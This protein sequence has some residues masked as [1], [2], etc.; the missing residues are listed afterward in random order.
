[1]K[2]KVIIAVI[3]TIALLVSSALIYVNNVFLPVKIKARLTQELENNL[4]KNVRIE[5]LRYS[6]IKGLAIQNLVIYDKSEDQTYLSAEEIS[7]NLLILPLFKK[8]IIIPFL[9]IDSPK[10]Y[11]KVKPDN[12]LNLMELFKTQTTQE[13][14]RFSFIISK[15]DLT[16]GTLQFSDERL[17]F[18]RKVTDLKI[19]A[20]LNLP[21]AI[22][23]ILQAKIQNFSASP[24]FI[25]AT[26]EYN[27]FK[28]DLAAKVKLANLAINDY[29]LY[30]NK[31]PLAL[32]DGVVNAD[33]EIGLKDRQLQVKGIT[34]ARGVKT[35][36]LD[37][38]LDI[39]GNINLSEN[40]LNW[41]NFVITYKQAKFNSSGNIID[42][43]QPKID[44]NVGAKDFT[45][46]TSLAIQDKIIK[47]NSCAG[48]YLNSEFSIN[49]N[50]DMRDNANPLINL[51]LELGLSLKDISAK[52]DGKCKIK[53][54][55]SG[56]IIKDTR[57][58]NAAL[59]FSAP[60]LSISD[61]KL[62]NLYFTLL[63]KN[64][65]ISINDLTAKLYSG[66]LNLQLAADIGK[67]LPTYTAKINLLN[68]DLAKLKMDTKFKDKDISGLLN[69]KSDI[70]QDLKD[71]NTLQGEGFI[72]IKDGKLWEWDLLKGV[73][74]LLFMPIY[75]KIIFRDARV[76]FNI[77]NKT[78]SIVDSSLES[79][80]LDLSAEGKIGF[81]G[82]LDL[83]LH[84]ELNEDLIK[85]SPDL[86]KFTSFI[87][88]NLIT[89][90]ITGT[91]QKPEYK[92]VPPAKEIINQLKDLLF[93]P[94]KR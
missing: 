12:T 40:N 36:V 41:E 20:G 85:E 45:S 32:S 90:K 35:Q 73:G 81:D 67:E 64:K 9:R 49:G 94:L 89:V 10:I 3:L 33:F 69:M 78:I 72:S 77:Q 21:G 44:F 63:Q 61:F 86:R 18:T 83:A 55:I 87:L 24:S 57:D 39:K 84:T 56:A 62:E 22:K 93:L 6:L 91:L 79:E 27:L 19:G 80:K 47:I 68:V 5:K 2:Y 65:L 71:L 92:V 59:E 58:L 1:M 26:G 53:G 8:K 38:P 74:E 52:L 42:F 76:N 7:L 34:D 14:P 16:N 75:Q 15:I 46:N 66:E 37:A 54:N 31:I 88:G 23:F 70:R 28:Q 51:G 4:G 11:L 82:S 25:S 17:K 48:K 50:I 60:A 43:K 13:K 30:L 29:L